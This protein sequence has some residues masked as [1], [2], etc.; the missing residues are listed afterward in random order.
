MRS[1]LRGKYKHVTCVT[2]PATHL[3]TTEIVLK[4]L[5]PCHKK[6]GMHGQLPIVCLLTIFTNPMQQEKMRR[7][8]NTQIL[9][10]KYFLS[11]LYKSAG[12]TEGRTSDYGFP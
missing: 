6:L 12:G 3:I 2:V 11:K 7:G 5:T 9:I 8:S 4:Q 1:H 10:I